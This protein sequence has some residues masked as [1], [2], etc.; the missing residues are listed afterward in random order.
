MKPTRRGKTAPMPEVLEVIRPPSPPAAAPPPAPAGSMTVTLR[1]G[2]RLHIGGASV[3]VVDAGGRKAKLCVRA[4]K[5]VPVWRE[6][7]A[8][9]EA[10]TP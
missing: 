5:T 6:P 7:R 8:V 9:K 10:A 1:I 3:E 2:D 4:H